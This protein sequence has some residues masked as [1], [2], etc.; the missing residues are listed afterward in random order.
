M[1]M[2]LF[3]SATDDATQHNT[4]KRREFFRSTGRISSFDPFSFFFS[5]YFSLVWSYFF[6]CDLYECG[7]LFRAA[8]MLV[9]CIKLSIETRPPSSHPPSRHFLSLISSRHI[10]IWLYPPNRPGLPS[11]SSSSSFLMVFRDGPCVAGLLVSGL[12]R[13]GFQEMKEA[14]KVRDKS[15]RALPIICTHPFPPILCC[16]PTH[17]LLASPFSLVDPLCVKC[18][19]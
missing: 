15:S 11:S 4:K 10:C 18:G 14:C 7:R 8:W 13:P 5:L 9:L 16:Q 19:C 6:F 12:Y 1:A 3:I 17:F 2:V